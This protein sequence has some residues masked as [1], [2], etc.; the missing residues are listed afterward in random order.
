MEGSFAEIRNPRREISD[1]RQVP[2]TAVEDSMGH[3]RHLAKG[4]SATRCLA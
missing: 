3:D 4:E 1:A 2:E